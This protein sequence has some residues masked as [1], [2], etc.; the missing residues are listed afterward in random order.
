M[1]SLATELGST[2]ARRFTK[3]VFLETLHNLFPAKSGALICHC[4]WGRRPPYRRRAMHQGGA[5]AAPK[6]AQA[7]P[8]AAGTR[9]EAAATGSA[10]PS[11]MDSVVLNLIDFFSKNS[12][13]NVIYFR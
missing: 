10:R 1:N 8:G 3:V 6:A 11:R 7:A 13:R 2:H 4:P 9:Q 12:R 5:R